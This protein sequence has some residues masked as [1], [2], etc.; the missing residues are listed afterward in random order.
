MEPSE[1]P[2]EMEVAEGF[3]SR[4]RHIEEEILLPHLSFKHSPAPRIKDKS[5]GKTAIKN[6]KFSG[7]ETKTW[8]LWRHDKDSS[9]FHLKLKVS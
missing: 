5:G 1:C 3:Q 4:Q 6:F 2:T 7:K 8:K 9:N